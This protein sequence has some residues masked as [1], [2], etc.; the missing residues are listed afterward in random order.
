MT[1][2]SLSEAPA[3]LPAEAQQ[4]WV[5]DDAADLKVGD[6][7]LLSWNRDALAMVVITK[8]I[9]DYILAC[10]VTLPTD[11]AFA[12][13]VVHEVTPLGLPL[14]IWPGIETGLGKHLLRRNLG[15]LLSE[16][17]VRLLRRYAEDGEESPLPVADGNYNDDGNP[18][19]LRG[20]LAYMQGLCF[21]EWPTDAPQDAVISADVIAQQ[22]A[23]IPFMTNTLGV[24]V[25][26]ARALLRQE[27]IPTD[28]EIA[29][30][31]SAWNLEPSA[32]LSAS[33]DDASQ[34]LIEPEFK[35]LLDQVMAAKGIDERAARRRS[36]QE[37][38]L[39]ARAAQPNDRI[40]RMRAAIERVLRASDG[41]A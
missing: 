4:R 22:G 13:A 35:P 18:E 1:T 40:A 23:G 26:R 19:H 7:W 29:G 14:T 6:L 25:P 32:L 36:Q 20:L 10:P 21:H 3:T 15:S 33:R 30:L 17:T 12:P 8:V 16:T 38:A 31:A 5:Q 11:P 28:A 24:D 2:L 39:A 34:T 27:A 37:Y 41:T 9:D